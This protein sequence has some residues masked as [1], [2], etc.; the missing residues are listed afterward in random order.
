VRRADHG[1]QVEAVTG[2]QQRRARGRQDSAEQHVAACCGGARG[3]RG[4]EHLAR[5]ARVADDEHPR[6]VHAGIAGRADGGAAERER[7]LGGQLLPGH[8][9][10]TVRAEQT[11]ARRDA[12]ISH[13]ET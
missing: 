6:A 1:G 4:L 11:P 2:E 3:Q 10:D 7:E 12:R 5:L 8:T 9:A 13:R